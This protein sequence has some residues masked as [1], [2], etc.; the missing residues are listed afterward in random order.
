M[1]KLRIAFGKFLQTRSN[2]FNVMIVC[3]NTGENSTAAKRRKQTFEVT[4]FLT[5][6]NGLFIGFFDLFSRIA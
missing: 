5:K 6:V 4:C 2:L 3:S 1:G